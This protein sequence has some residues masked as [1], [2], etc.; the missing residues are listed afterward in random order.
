MP[1]KKKPQP[2]QQFF[3][4]VRDDKAT[5]SLDTI[6]WC[7]RHGGV[8][9][10]AEN[11]DGHTAVQIAAAANKVQVLEV[12]CDWVKQSGLKDDLDV[13][14]DEGRTALMMAAAKGH[15]ECCKMLS[16]AGASWT[17]KCDDG[18]TARDYAAKRGNQPL[19][20]MFDGGLEALKREKNVEPEDDGDDAEDE[21]KKKKWRMASL[22]ANKQAEREAATHEARLRERDQIESTLGTAP[23]AVWPEVKAVIES[24]GRE[25]SISRPRSDDMDPA[26]WHCI[27]LNLLRLRVEDQSLA[28][29]PPQ[30]G[31]LNAL[32]TLIVSQCG[33]VELPDA[34]S[35]LTKLRVLE[36]AGNKL[37]TLPAALGSCAAL[38]V[39]QLADNE[40]ESADVLEQL[41][42]VVTLNLDRNRLARLPLPDSE[43][44]KT[45]SAAS[46]QI[47]EV[48][49]A[50][51]RLQ[52][53]REL[54]LTDN[55]LE[56]LPAELAN[57]TPKVRA[58][59]PSADR[60]PA[61][62][63]TDRALLV[64]PRRAWRDHRCCR[65][66]PSRATR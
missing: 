11:D 41:E 45:I 40:L 60:V 66:W 50:V 8:S 18:M 37:R 23:E 62:D 65:S 9:V 1:A 33:L 19:I 24:K 4:A 56:G 6:R 36:A 51:G 15:V 38:E 32:A 7:L 5:R 26:L 44:L 58:R 34:V 31:Q 49:A 52:L 39:L 3:N 42:A 57:L 35:A 53:L 48:P 28:R 54:T 29:L 43:H 63:G 2:R 12:L 64:P 46:N 20:A 55:Q 10:R 21:A 59:T 17:A 13:T 22:D 30:L 14:D 16:K 27:T 61:R 47:T 25:L